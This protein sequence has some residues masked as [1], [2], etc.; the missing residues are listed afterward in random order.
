MVKFVSKRCIFFHEK[1]FLLSNLQY[2]SLNFD[3]KTCSHTL[4]YLSASSL[5]A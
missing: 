1:I 2:V 5:A 4:L 3:S